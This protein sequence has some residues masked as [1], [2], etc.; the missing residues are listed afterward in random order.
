MNESV[1]ISSLT[2]NRLSVYLRCLRRLHSEGTE[3]ISSAEFASRFRLSA[4]Q[5]RKDLAH[6]GE[7]GIRGVGYRVEDLK[8]RLEQLLGLD[9]EHRAVIVG[10]G[11]LGTALARFPGFQ[12]S[13]FRVVALFDNDMAKVTAAGQRR[14]DIAPPL[15]HSREMRSRLASLGA[16][17][18]ILTV[19]A[20]AAQS[21]YDVLADCGVSAVLNFAPLRLAERPDV[22]VKTV[23][24]LIFM[25]ELAFLL[26]SRAET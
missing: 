9:C 1:E 2:I 20:H 23:D 14:A 15:F 22:P 7:L 10:A 13:V 6:F 19:P 3:N 25:E 8:S 11:N 4:S 12:S 5:I 16:E 18:G 21:N 17:L 24:I 26:R